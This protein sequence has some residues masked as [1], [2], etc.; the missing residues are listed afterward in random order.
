MTKAEKARFNKFLHRVLKSGGLV[1]NEHLPD[2]L[3]LRKS[4]KGGYTVLIPTYKFLNEL[5]KFVAPYKFK[6]KPSVE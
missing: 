1:A 5:K 2:R 3:R 6:G 4:T